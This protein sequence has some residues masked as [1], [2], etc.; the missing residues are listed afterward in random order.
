[1]A[2]GQFISQGR[3]SVTRRWAQGTHHAAQQRFTQPVPQLAILL[4]ALDQKM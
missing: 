4:V 2:V 1:M 3:D